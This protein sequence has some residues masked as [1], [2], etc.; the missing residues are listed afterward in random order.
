MS[1]AEQLL[2]AVPA[3]EQEAMVDAAIEACD[4]AI[5]RHMAAHMGNWSPARL[6]EVAASRGARCVLTPAPDMPNGVRIDFE[7]L[8]VPEFLAPER[9][10]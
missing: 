6:A 9:T 7:P 5:R 4:Q 10:Q 1:R 8:R 3:E 2:A